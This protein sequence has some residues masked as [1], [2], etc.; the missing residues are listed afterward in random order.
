MGIKNL[1]KWIKESCKT[2][3][4]CMALS[5]L[6]GKK[7]VVDISIYIYKYETENALME[8]M[9]SLLS[10]LKH[11]NIV[12]LFVFDGKPPD[13]KKQLLLQ[14]KQYKEL[15]KENYDVLELECQN[16]DM[17]NIYR[18]QLEVEMEQLKKQF[19]S[20]SKEKI[21]K[22]KDL[23]RAYGFQSIVAPKEADELCA[24]LVI[25]K[26]VWACLSEDMDLF[27]YGCTRVLRYISLLNHTVVVYN[28][29]GILYDLDISLNE[30]QEICIL[31]GTDYNINMDQIEKNNIKEIV[32]LYHLY[33]KEKEEKEVVPNKTDYNFYVWLEEKGREIDKIQLKKVIDM[34]TI[35][36]KN[37][38]WIEDIKIKQDEKQEE[39]VRKMMEKEDF[40]F[41]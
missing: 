29:K 3:I 24:M 36:V 41:I 26:K 23:I 1:N 8:N 39:M 13:E 9:Y 22:V 15:A 25:E 4:E 27:V 2:A 37:N 38:K 18:K 30:F 11:Y 34:F 16:L 28:M 21:K 40:V 31:S 17:D 10:L 14:R 6:S 19:V 33:R 12:A 32:N 35:D 5:K 7:I 20:I